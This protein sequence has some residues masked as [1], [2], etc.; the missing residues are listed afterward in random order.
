MLQSIQGNLNLDLVVQ[1]LLLQACKNRKTK[2]LVTP[3]QLRTKAAT[4][5][6]DFIPRTVGSEN[7]DNQ[8]VRER[9]KSG[10]ETL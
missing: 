7:K 10:A 1:L 8:D 3:G 2:K 5:A 9:F 4:T 6:A